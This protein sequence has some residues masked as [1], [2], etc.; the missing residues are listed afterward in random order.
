MKSLYLA[1]CMLAGYLLF[2]D[3]GI[4]GGAVAYFILRFIEE[5]G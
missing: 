1:F 5:M 2:G 4:A 3:G